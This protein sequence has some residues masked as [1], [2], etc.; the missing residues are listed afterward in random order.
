MEFEFDKELEGSSDELLKLLITY[1]SD[2]SYFIEVIS[3]H[4]ELSLLLVV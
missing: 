3:I 4:T 1:R 2:G